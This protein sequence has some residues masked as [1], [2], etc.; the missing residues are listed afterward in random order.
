MIIFHTAL[1]AEARALIRHFR[2]KRQHAVHAFACFRNDDYFLI[3]SGIGKINTAAA[4]AWSQAHLDTLNPVM[5]NIGMAG[6]KDK[7]IGDLYIAHRIEDK[8]SGHRVYP[9]M[10]GRLNLLSDNLLTLDHPCTDY[11]QD[12]MLDM[13]ASAFFHTASRFTTLELIQSIKVISD[14][15]E[16]PARRMKDKEVE[17]LISPH[18]LAIHNTATALAALR[19]TI[20]PTPSRD[21]LHI[22]QKW[23]FSQYQQQQLKRLLQ[24]HHA[25]FGR[26]QIRERLPA[27]LSSSKQLLSWLASELASQ[28]LSYP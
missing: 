19:T 14:N 12:I 21:Y 5:I 7:T 22:T 13:E 24:R 18:L 16:N 6:H 11:P 15:Q 2:L 27:S 8:T 20:T 28:R 23:H 26:D 1:H 17:A 4:V 10:T 3:E 9:A 25:L